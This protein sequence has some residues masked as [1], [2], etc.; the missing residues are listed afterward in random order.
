MKKILFLAHLFLFGC[1]VSN[2][3]NN[4]IP[5]EHLIDSISTTNYSLD[6]IHNEVVKDSINQY[7]YEN[8]SIIQSVEVVYLSQNELYFIIRSKNKALNL[9]SRIEG[10]AISNDEFDYEIDEDE[11]GNA[12]P[13]KQYFYDKNC[14][15]S[16]RIDAL[17]REMLKVFVFECKDD[18]NMFCPLESLSVLRKV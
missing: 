11:N 15:I 7:K 18:N 5:L 9:E 10:N 16:I 2:E 13:S 1:N 12:Y 17:N 3:K 14:S 4:D 8:D 6:S